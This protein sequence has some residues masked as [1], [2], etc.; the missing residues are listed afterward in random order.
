MVWTAS[1]SGQSSSI[2]PVN[3]DYICL[4]NEGW[5]IKST[6]AVEFA[7]FL[8]LRRLAD[9]TVAWTQRLIVVRTTT[10][11]TSERSAVLLGVLSYIED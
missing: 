10:K 9:N 2:E 7:L 8:P 5:I 3:Y 1:S 4:V 6:Q 11:Q